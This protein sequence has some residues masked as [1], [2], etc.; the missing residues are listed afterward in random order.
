VNAGDLFG[1]DQPCAQLPKPVEV[2]DSSGVAFLDLALG[3]EVAHLDNRTQVAFLG[4]VE[5]S[6][7]RHAPRPRQRSISGKGTAEPFGASAGSTGPAPSGRPNFWASR[8][9]DGL[10][11]P[12]V[13]IGMTS[14]LA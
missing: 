4:S 1:W 6:R 3:A 13:V 8:S 11:V 14:F 5:D 7:E 2:R 9:G 10:D 12:F